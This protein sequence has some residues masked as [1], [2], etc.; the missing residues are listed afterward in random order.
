[1]GQVGAKPQETLV[2]LLTG[3]SA[4]PRMMKSCVKRKDIFCSTMIVSVDVSFKV[5]MISL[6]STVEFGA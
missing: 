4:L 2:I 5:G 1:M 3:S 6:G